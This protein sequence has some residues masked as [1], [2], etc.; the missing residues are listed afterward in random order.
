MKCVFS[1][2]ILFSLNISASVSCCPTHSHSIG[3]CH[4]PLGHASVTAHGSTKAPLPFFFFFL[5]PFLLVFLHSPVPVPFFI[6]F[7]QVFI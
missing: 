7:Y 3:M 6:F 4:T 2:F 5:F 1:N